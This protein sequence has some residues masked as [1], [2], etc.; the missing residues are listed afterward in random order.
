MRSVCDR[1]DNNFAVSVWFYNRLRYQYARQGLTSIFVDEMKLE[2]VR[3]KYYPD[4]VSRLRGVYLFETPEDV[5]EAL[6][7]WSV[8]RDSIYVSAVN[9]STSAVTRV[10]S[11]WITQCLGRGCQDKSWIHAYWQGKP[12]GS[13]PL[14]ELLC[15]GVGLIVSNELRRHAYESICKES[16]L[17]SKILSLSATAF[18][19]GH[20]EVGRLCARVNQEREHGARCLLH[21][22][23]S[24]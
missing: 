19:C 21:R 1:D 23:A 4:K 12:Y 16:P 11:E 18:F 24:L 22:H 9:F 8:N 6:Q 3:R 7:R 13:R 2:A 20:E 17:S 14:F 10:D 5:E 15:S